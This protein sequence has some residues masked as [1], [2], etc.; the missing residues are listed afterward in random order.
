MVWR[1]GEGEAGNRPGIR[2][3]PCAAQLFEFCINFEKLCREARLLQLPQDGQECPPAGS[4]MLLEP[5]Q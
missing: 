3:G 5:Y 2:P 4:V 1:D